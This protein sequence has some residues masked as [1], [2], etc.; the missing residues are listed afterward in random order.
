MSE[1]A[2]LRRHCCPVHNE[3][4]ILYIM[5]A[6]HVLQLPQD[7]DHNYSP[8]LFLYTEYNIQI[9]T[10]YIGILIKILCNCR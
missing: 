10:K 3:M 1:A 9:T 6:S 7:G 4:L 5:I 8:C 2:S